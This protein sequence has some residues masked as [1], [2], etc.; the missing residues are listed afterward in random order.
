MPE[1][2]KSIRVGDLVG[3]RYKGLPG[4]LCP[5]IV[6]KKE[7]AYP[8]NPNDRCLVMF[9]HS[10]PRVATPFAKKYW[11]LEKDLVLLAR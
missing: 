1:K 8:G 2:D 4:V 9:S 6:V 10:H 3:K 11:Q 5:G 7:A